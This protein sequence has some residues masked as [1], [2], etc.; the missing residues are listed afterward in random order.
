MNSKII[1]YASEARTKLKAGVDKLANAVKVTLGPKGRNVIINNQFGPVTV[2]KDG[3]TVAKN[4]SLEDQ[5]EN[6]GALLVKEASS[7]T[8]EEAGDGTTT[9]VLLTQ[10]IFAEGLKYIESGA[11]PVDLKRGIDIAVDKVVE[12]LKTIRQTISTKNQI[13]QIATISAN[14]DEKIGNLISDAMEQVGKDGAIIVDSLYKDRA[15]EMEVVQGYQFD[16]GFIHPYLVTN[17]EKMEAEYISLPNQP[18][19]LFLYDKK[20]SSQKDIIPLM[21][22]AV[23]KGATLVIIC[24]DVTGE[25]LA[26]LVANK[27][28][29]TIRAIAIKSPSYGERK[30]DIMNDLAIATGATYVS[31]EAGISLN[32]FIPDW[33][34]EVA[35]IVVN[36]DYTTLF[37]ADNPKLKEAAAA[38]AEEIRARYDATPTSQDY[39]R[40]KL[41]ERLAKLTSGIAVLKIGASTETEI[42][43]KKDRVDDA[44]HATK[45]AIEEGIVVGG[46][47]AFINCSAM[48][49]TITD[50]GCKNTDQTLGYNIVKRAIELPL[51]TIVNNSGKSGEVALEKVKEQII[52]DINT[53]YGY[54]AATDTYGNLI[55]FGVLDPAKVLRVSLQNASSAAGMLLISECVITDVPNEK[56]EEMQGMHP[57]M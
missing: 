28:K 29:G 48:L 39:E 4:I 8:S 19:W 40:G 36:K 17:S 38:R 52:V 24:E 42:N 27:L 22:A 1:I 32:K 34:G 16:K 2:T 37:M 35:K 57:A 15:T 10:A 51:I 3:I 54:N 9:A 12:Y 46:G 44:V 55:E 47:V 18:V 25:A 41:Q 5:Q 43:E 11:N 30:R 21:E 13:T 49:D 23:N 26:T 7:K 56:D 6:M 50:T 31:E 53:S 20:I 33:F 45:A 14:G